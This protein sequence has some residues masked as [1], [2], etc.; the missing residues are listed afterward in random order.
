MFIYPVAW[1]RLIVQIDWNYIFLSYFCRILNT[2][3][4]FN[5]WYRWK[6]SYYSHVP[7]CFSVPLFCADRI[8]LLKWQ[9][10]LKRIMDASGTRG[11][12]KSGIFGRLY[13]RSQLLWWQDKE[14]LG[15]SARNGWESLLMY[16]VSVA[17]NG[18]MCPGKPSNWRKNTVEK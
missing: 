13:Y 7:S 6:A 8:N 4:S 2:N 9:T 10:L 16:M 15:F 11:K 18:M 3:L 12:E 14:I 17:G 5:V 1:M